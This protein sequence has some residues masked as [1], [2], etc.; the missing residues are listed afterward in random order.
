MNSGRDDRR[1]RFFFLWLR[2]EQRIRLVIAQTTGLQ[3]Q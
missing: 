2:R 3:R 1:G